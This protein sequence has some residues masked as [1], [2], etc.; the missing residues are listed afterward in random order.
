MSLQDLKQ[1]ARQFAKV[2][3]NVVSQLD[4][5]PSVVSDETL[6]VR[7]ALRTYTKVRP[8]VV[9]VDLT[10]TGDYELSLSAISG[11]HPDTHQVLSVSWPIGIQDQHAISGNEITVYQKSGG[12]W[13]LRFNCRTPDS[14][15]SVE[16]AKPHD[17]N[18]MA[19]NAPADIEAICHLAA[20]NI[21]RIAA[22]FYASQH[23][24]NIAADISN[25]EQQSVNYAMRAKDEEKKFWD[26]LGQR[27]Q[28]SSAR[29]NLG[30]PR[31]NEPDLFWNTRRGRR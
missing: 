31:R 25:S 3:S 24:S 27:R 19:A 15:V 17:E 23:S 10:A 11:Y 9:V 29:A 18:L 30:L 14:T 13:W 16:L 20:A 22:N 28:T 12:T 4:A 1:M 7:D 26:Y 8:L 5:L 6:A 2:S 21:L